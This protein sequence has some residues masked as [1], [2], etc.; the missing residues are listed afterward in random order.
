M[1]ISILDRCAEPGTR[2]EDTRLNN[3]LVSELNSSLIGLLSEED[4]LKNMDE[5][6]GKAY[7][8]ALYKG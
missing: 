6:G 1:H 5:K 8:S 4:I 3:R 2:E 7:E